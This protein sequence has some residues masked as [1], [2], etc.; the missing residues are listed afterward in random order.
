MLTD[1]VVSILVLHEEL[2]WTRAIVFGDDHLHDTATLVLAPVLDALLDD[3]GGEFVFGELEEVFGDEGDD[4]GFVCW[5]AVLDD[6]LGYL[7]VLV[8]VVLWGEKTNVVAVLILD[9]VVGA[10]VEFGEDACLGFLVAV[11]QHSLDYPTS[12]WMCRQRVNLSV[13]GIDNELDML[14]WNPLDSLLDNVVSVLVL[15]A[16]EDMS[17]KLFNEL[18]LLVHKDMFERLSSR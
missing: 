15:D 1:Y 14:S 16:G 6:V 9:E 13:E 5:L 7:V 12:I 18:S 2:E 17:I 11:L 8:G 10:D 4:F 3:V